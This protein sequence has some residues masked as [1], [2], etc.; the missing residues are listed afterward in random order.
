M[1]VENLLRSVA[2]SYLHFNRVDAYRDFPSADLADGAELP[3]DQAGNATI[4]FEKAPNFTLSHYYAASRG[5]T[6]ACCFSLENSQH[7]WANYGLGSAKGQVGV[8][9]DFE[10][11]RRR[12][13]AS[14][15]HGQAALMVGAFPCHQIFS[16]NYGVVDYVPRDSHR[17]N[18]A[19]AP[20]PIEY[21]FLKDDRFREERELRVSLSTLGMGHFV[22]ADGTKVDFPPS[23]T[24]EL[25]FR[26]ALADG[27]IVELLASGSTDSAYLA[28]E[29]EKLGILAQ[30]TASPCG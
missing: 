1:T 29:L 3:G 8:V 15:A 7:L 13:N 16:I 4:G 26:G 2:G 20:N 12:L 28:A 6:Y 17:A 27:T 24:L 11:L 14:L 21:A 30:G 10:K 23:L 19:R 22:L 5:R 18:T 9:F 25:D